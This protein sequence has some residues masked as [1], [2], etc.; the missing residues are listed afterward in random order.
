M[1]QDAV[2]VVNII[3]AITT[4]VLAIATFG[5]A[6][7]T[8][9]AAE[10]TEK[11]IEA[12]YK[13]WV[14]MYVK[15]NWQGSMIDLLV[16]NSGFGPAYDISFNLPDYFPYYA[17]GIDPETADMPAN[18]VGGPLRNGMSYLAPGQQWRSYWGQYGALLKGLENKPVEVEISFSTAKGTKEISRCALDIRDLTESATDNFEKQTVNALKD[19][20]KKTGE[21]SRALQ[22]ISRD[23]KNRQPDSDT[24]E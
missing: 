6:Y 11:T 3:V 2:L 13:P 21:I 4:G 18:W 1:S 9:R 10:A 8:K 19:Q 24:K 7:A 23:I 20:A 17:E 5:V 12:Q 15:P 22:S 16:E 14:I